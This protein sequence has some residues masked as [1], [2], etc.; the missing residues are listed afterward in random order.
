[1]FYEFFFQT[2]WIYLFR[3]GSQVQG[4][5]TLIRKIK[6]KNL[7]DFEYEI[8]WIGYL[9]NPEDKQLIDMNI[10]FLDQLSENSKTKNL[11]N[12]NWFN[13]INKFF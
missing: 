6:I 12:Y 13:L 11:S 8:N 2:C 5:S 7:C 3:L 9:T 10:N 1:M 4:T